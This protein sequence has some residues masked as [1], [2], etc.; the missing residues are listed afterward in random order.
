MSVFEG[1]RGTDISNTFA[2][3]LPKRISVSHLSQS[4][5]DSLTFSD[6]DASEYDS[7]CGTPCIPMHELLASLS[8][9]DGEI[10]NGRNGYKKIGTICD[11]RQGE[12]YKAVK[13]DGSDVE[14]A[15]KRT[16]KDMFEKRIAVE[17]GFTFVVPDNC[18][19]EAEILKRVTA[20]DT[21]F[22]KHIVQYIDFFESEEDYYL[23]MEYVSSQTN[24]KQFVAQAKQH[25][26]NGTLSIE[27]YQKAVKQLM[28]QLCTTVQWLH[29][30]M[31][32]CHLKLRLENIMVE[33]ASFMTTTDGMILDPNICIKLCD[34]GVSNQFEKDDVSRSTLHNDAYS[35]PKVFNEEV[36]DPQSVD[37]WRLGMIMFECMTG[38]K[39]IYKPLDVGVVGGGH[40]ALMHGQLE[41]YLKQKKMFS[42]YFNVQSFALLSGLLKANDAKRLHGMGILRESW[43][44]T[45]YKRDA[46]E[47]N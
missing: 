22:S 32:C 3:E 44:E 7:P 41:T 4:S 46:I 16:A 40:W 23:V 11:T 10:A 34:F 47:A 18:V 5:T 33:N 15:I 37:N 9:M 1:I 14:F 17:Y 6:C 27:E 35:A 38:G 28:W 12:L 26:A 39:Q 36:Y 8:I 45:Y 21:S 20:D 30:S 2:S 13:T 19:K 42:P 43:F 25:M 29:V 31:K 24:L